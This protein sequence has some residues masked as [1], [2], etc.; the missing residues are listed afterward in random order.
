MISSRSIDPTLLCVSRLPGTAAGRVSASPRAAGKL[1]QCGGDAAWIHRPRRCAPTNGPRR[2]R[3]DC[4]HCL[5]DPYERYRFRDALCTSGRGTRQRRPTVTT[6][7]T[8]VDFRVID[9]YPI[10]RFWCW[11]GPHYLLERIFGEYFWLWF[12]AFV[13]ILL[14]P[15]LYFTLRGNIDVDPTNWRRVSASLH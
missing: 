6:G 8:R 11:I 2:A 5:F 3:W 15:F 13:N 12:A 4:G 1:V 7:G 10:P 9:T 14:Y